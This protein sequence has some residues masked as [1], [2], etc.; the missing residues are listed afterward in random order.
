MEKLLDPRGIPQA[1]SWQ[2]YICGH[3]PHGH[4][5]LFDAQS[6]PIA[7]AV[8]SAGDAREVAKLID[9]QNPNFANIKH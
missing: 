9:S 7:Q 4:L 5:V 3:C 6:Q 8:M 2:L 1:D